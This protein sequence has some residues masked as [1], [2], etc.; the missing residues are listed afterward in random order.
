MRSSRHS[1][2][3]LPGDVRD[4]IGAIISDPW[5]QPGGHRLGDGRPECAKEEGRA[6]ARRAP[7]AMPGERGA[8]GAQGLPGAP[9]LQGQ[10]GERGEPGPKGDTA[11]PDPRVTRGGRDLRANRRPRGRRAS[12]LPGQGRKVPGLKGEGTLQAQGEPAQG[13]RARPGAP[14]AKGEQARAKGPQGPKQVR[15]ARPSRP[16][17][18]ARRSGIRGHEPGAQQPGTATGRGQGPTL[19]VLT[20]RASNSCQADEVMISAYC[21]SSATEI[22]SAPI[23]I[24]PRSARCVGIL[25]ATVV[26]TCCAN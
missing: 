14:G 1:M 12:G 7:R 11:R 26:I 10:K 4:D 3:S 19:R 24:P 17:G 8:Q 22:T 5:N 6:S 15:Q 18:E 23:I 9:G 13:Q 25:N 20:G 2:R 16:K 21:T